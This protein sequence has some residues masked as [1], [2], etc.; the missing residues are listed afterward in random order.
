MRHS[1]FLLALLVPLV[2]AA[3][4]EECSAL[5]QL[6]GAPA[7]DADQTSEYSDVKYFIRSHFGHYLKDD[8]GWPMLTRNRDHWEKWN[9]EHIGDGRVFLR[10]HFGK[11][12]KD[13]QGSVQESHN[14]DSW[15]MWSI[16]P[17]GWNEVFLRGYHGQYLMDNRGQ[18]M[19][20]PNA[21]DWER[22][23]LEEHWQPGW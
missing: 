15:E 2:V 16:V 14:R 4:N 12:L 13:H 1:Q 18:L 21:Q 9:L 10:G 22:W 5:L 23:T 6:R 11:Y 19:M 7:A 17:A 3:E 8:N 20:S